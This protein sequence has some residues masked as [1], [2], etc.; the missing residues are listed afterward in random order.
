MNIDITF[1]LLDQDFVYKSDIRNNYQGRKH[2]YVF[3]WGRKHT[4]RVILSPLENFE[5]LEKSEISTWPDPS[6]IIVY[7]SYKSHIRVI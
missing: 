3:P 7:E 1:S 5:F 4:F 2:A 6:H